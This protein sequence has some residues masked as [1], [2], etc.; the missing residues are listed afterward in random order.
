MAKK[1]SDLSKFWSKINKASNKKSKKKS[2]RLSSYKN[3]TLGYAALSVFVL[4]LS[5]FN[6]Q[7]YF[8]P[9]RVSTTVH[10]ARDTYQEELA[11]WTD[12]AFKHPD[13]IDAWLALAELDK[14]HGN[15]E[16]AKVWINKAKEINPNSEKV[17][18]VI[19]KYN[20]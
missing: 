10:A 5:A 8:S 18:E 14:K 6:I 2:F 7:T 9:Q 3:S 19:L 4:S 15:F 16:K 20:L 11:F 1:K 17:Q 12:L 13:Y